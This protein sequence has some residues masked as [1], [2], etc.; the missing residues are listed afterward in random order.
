MRTIF[1]DAHL[2]GA[3]SPSSVAVLDDRIEAVGPTADALAADRVVDVAGGYLGPAFRDGHAHPDAAGF[4]QTGPS[5]RGCT[6]VE[7]IAAAVRE[8]ADRHPELE[9]IRGGS[10]DATIVPG[11]LFDAAWLDAAVPDRPVVLRAWDYHAI[12]CNS[13]AMRRAGLDASTQDTRRGS[14]PRRPD[15]SLLGTMLESD[16]VESVLDAAPPWTLEERVRALAT[17]TAEFARAGVAWIQD[18]L[19]EHANVDGYLV[20]AERGVLGTRVNL[21]FRADPVRWREQLAEIEADRERVRLLGHDRLT[22]QTVK[23]FVDGILENHTAM[24]IEPYADDPCAHGMELWDEAELR[25]AMAHVDAL[26][27][28][29]HLHA[30][31][32]AGIRRALDAVAHLDK[33]NGPR[34]RRPV[35]AH[36]QVVDP[37]DLSRFR[38][39][40]V[41]A[42]F[43]PIWSQLDP[44]MEVLTRPRLGEERFALQY[45]IGA[46]SRAGVAVSFGSDWPV[47]DPR[48]LVGL[49]VAMTRE[50]AA[51]LPA[52]GW[53]P[54]QRI[55]IEEAL[56]AYTTAGA[57]QAFEER[58]RGALVPGQFADLVWLSAD[59]R[60][61]TPQQLGGIDVLATLVA[62]RVTHLDQSVSGSLAA[63]ELSV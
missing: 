17:A 31:G 3:S 5:I 14:Y 44:V 16:A 36:V 27:F 13:E 41:I 52:G 32:D 35:I 19:V 22:A 33:V 63:E 28:Q 1:R 57:H 34:D 51:G 24:L 20:A 9:W 37:T 23:F 50:T 49:P 42:N 11:G 45:P 43:Q 53:L 25:A 56:A 18:A 48:P 40:G 7:Q 39:L 60:S 46:L 62:G 21:A 6:S 58:V 2:P 59:P 12:W 10:Y 8:Y 4:E 55:R 61:V 30:I 47:G 26:G 29:C 38:E 15:G 54:E